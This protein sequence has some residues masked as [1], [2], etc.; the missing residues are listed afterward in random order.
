MF[1]SV[2][3]PAPFSPSRPRTS[4]ARIVRLTSELAT[5]L[6]EPLGDAA[7]LDVHDPPRTAP[8]AYAA[9]AA[10]K[11]RPPRGAAGRFVRSSGPSRP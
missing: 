11:P 3:L 4:P 8:A 5:T 7:Q 1:I 9:G 10:L 6:A 2:V